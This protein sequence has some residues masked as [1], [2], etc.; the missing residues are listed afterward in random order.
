MEQRIIRPFIL[1]SGTK[2]KKASVSPQ[3]KVLNDLI[4]KSA[5]ESSCSRANNQKEHNN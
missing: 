4:R 1:R 3:V 5:K 2:L